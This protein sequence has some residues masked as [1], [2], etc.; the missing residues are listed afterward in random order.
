MHTRT[1]ILSVQAAAA[2]AA[3]LLVGPPTTA[4]EPISTLY[5]IRGGRV[6]TVTGPVIDSGTVLVRNGVIEAVGADLTVPPDALVIDATG[7][8]VYPGLID[9]GNAAPIDTGDE[10]AAAGARGAFGGG[11]GRGGGGS[12]EQFATLEDAERAKRETILQPHFM[13]AANLRTGS[14]AQQALASAGIT[15]VLA[16]PSSGIFKGQ[17]ALVNVLVAPDDP[18]ISAIADYRKGLAVVKSPVASHIDMGGRGGGQGYP[19]SL[20]GTIAFTRQE[21]LNAQWQRDAVAHYERT[22]RGQRPLVE[23][24]LTALEP[25]LTGELR[26]AFDANLARE[27]DRALAVAAEFGLDPILVGAAEADARTDEIKAADASVIFSL[28]LPGA[29]SGRGGRAG[30][31]GFGGRG[32]GASPSLRQMLAEENAPK[33]PAAL[34]AAGIPF[35]FT[36]GGLSPA[37]FVQSARRIVGD[38]GLSADQA[39][40]A[41]TIDAATLAG[42]ADRTGSL[43]AGKI[44]NLL[45]TE[46]DLLTDGRVRHVFIDGQPVEITAAPATPATGRGRGG[47]R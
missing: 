23:P 43:E 34:A 14:D 26:A 46:G 45:V 39:L 20:L 8:N 38:G 40:R 15:T 13:A 29:G 4:Q 31:G 30:G 35:A 37:D 16:V 1:R 2:L 18:Q 24:P 10:P 21:L 47:G 5:A 41:L 22:G 19:A 25:V 27:I 7:L 28:N 9:M 3:A 17:S 44:A 42:A 6:F 12:G 36:S 33:I 11:G 32:G